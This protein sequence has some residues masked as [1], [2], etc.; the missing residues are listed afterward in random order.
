MFMYMPL[1]YMLKL[2][3]CLTATYLFYVLLLKGLTHYNWNRLFLLTC[4]VLSFVAPL[5]NINLFVAPEKLTGVFFVNRIP[6]ISAAISA[7]SAAGSPPFNMLL[8]MFCIFIAGVC[9]LTVRLLLQFLSLKR[10]QARAELVSNGEIKLYHLNTGIAPFSFN[11]GIYLDKDKYNGQELD[12]V[13]RH[14]MV[15]VNQKHTIDVL[16]AELLCILNWYNPFAWLIKHALK[17][18]L[19]FIADDIVLQNSQNR[20]SYQYLL[21]KVTGNIPCS[22]TNNLNYSSLKKRIEMMN[23]DK[24]SNRH[25]LKFLFIIPMVSILLLAFRH[26]YEKQLPR[27]HADAALLADEYILETLTYSINDAKVEAIV[28]KEEANSFL[29]PGDTLSLS[30]LKNEKERLAELLQKNGYANLSAH[31]ITFEVDTA[32]GNKKFSVQVNINVGQ[33]KNS[34]HTNGSSSSKA[35]VTGYIENTLQ[36]QT[37]FVSEKRNTG[38]Y[39][40]GAYNKM[41]A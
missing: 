26:A 32:L 17:E 24:T 11:K 16:V 38:K 23:S 28:K 3:L 15:H 4:T 40:N 19:E 34:V 30:T 2:S 6:A 29:K 14:E 18:N 41:N 5:I 33:N 9:V 22:I 12:E 25:L 31:A 8:L 39:I 27:K 10:I 7:N 37:T 35:P 36:E 21:L 1:E 20:K 13:I